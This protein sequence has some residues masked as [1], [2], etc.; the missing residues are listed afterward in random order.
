MIPRRL[1]RGLGASGGGA[2]RAP[3][4]PGHA[5]TATRDR[6]YILPTRYGYGFAGMIAV[7]FLGAI[8]YS[9][10][11]AFAMTF[12]LVA[13]GANGMWFTYRNLAGLRVYPP[14]TEPVFAGQPAPFHYRLEETEGRPR[15]A[16]GLQPKG[17]SAVLTDVA[18]GDTEPTLLRVPTQRRGRQPAGPVRLTSRYPFGLFYGWLPLPFTD[19]CLVY[20]EPYRA[21][22]P[23]EQLAQQSRGRWATSP[24]SEDFAGLRDYH[25]GDSPRRIAWHAVARFDTLLVKQFAAQASQELWLDWDALP[26]RG[27]ERRLSQLCGWVLAADRDG[28]RYGLHLPGLRIAP[29]QGSPHRDRCLA[30]LALYRLR[31]E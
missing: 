19:T 8:N 28:F 31:D 25:Q 22:L 13:I 2:A 29:N 4:A 14:R 3:A 9:N 17:Q 6:L 20:P 26:G 7:M 27:A 5:V 18:A 16:V 23:S 12:L 10:S 30:A 21:P 15:H 24:G 11:M 1:A